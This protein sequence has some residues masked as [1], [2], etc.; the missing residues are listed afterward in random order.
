MN[1]YYVESKILYKGAYYTRKE[2]NDIKNQENLAITMEKL[3]AVLE[4]T[5]KIL[6][7]VAPK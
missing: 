1:S 4:K 2:Y 3:T 6:E 5:I 7:T